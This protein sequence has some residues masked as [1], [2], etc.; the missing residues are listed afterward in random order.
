MAR[1]LLTLATLAVLSMLAAAVLGFLAP[2][3]ERMPLYH[4]L[5][6][7][8]AAL[9]TTFIHCM[10]MFYFI[11]TSKV[12]REAAADLGSKERDYVKET[13]RLAAV[14]HPFATLAIAVTMAGTF[15]GG[16]VRAGLV[17]PWVHLV[18]IAAALGVNLWVF[19]KEQRAAV[20]NSTL[21]AELEDFYARK[22]KSPV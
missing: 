21:I 20:V 12:I 17:P 8:F 9:F 1:A 18:G 6:G 3:S 2:A 5:A 10:V 22:A 15:L 13:R 14:V 7:L 16:A 19:A 4:L 11:G